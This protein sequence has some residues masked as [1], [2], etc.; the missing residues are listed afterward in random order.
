[1]LLAP[2]QQVGVLLAG[3]PFGRQE[4]VVIW[5]TT[6]ILFARCALSFRGTQFGLHVAT[7]SANPALSA[8]CRAT[9]P[10]RSL[11]PSA[12]SQW[13][14]VERCVTRASTVCCGRTTRRR[15]GSG[16][17]QRHEAGHDDEHAA[18]YRSVSQLRTAGRP[19]GRPHW[20][21]A[22]SARRGGRGPPWR[23]V[24]VEDPRTPHHV[25]TVRGARPAGC[26]RPSSWR[27]ATATGPSSSAATPPARC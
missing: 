22:G 8:S 25:R 12:A 4:P 2:G 9:V 21:A 16:H 27:G 23:A 20:L 15:G 19:G 10:L 17:E 5:R 3:S 13:L 11:A 6:T 24:G 7:P 18:A 1:M 26:S 14:R